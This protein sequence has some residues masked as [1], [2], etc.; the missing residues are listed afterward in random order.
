MRPVLIFR[1]LVY[2]LRNPVSRLI[3]FA[4]CTYIIFALCTY[5]GFDIA[6]TSAQDADT[7]ASG[8]ESYYV[9]DVVGGAPEY[10]YVTLNGLMDS[11]YSFVEVTKERYGVETSKNPK[12]TI[13]HAL[14]TEE[15]AMNQG[16]GEKLHADVLVKT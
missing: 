16:T 5:A 11:S 2:L 12:N 3:I 4:L 9:E 8:P 1:L 14:F 6:R 10:D 15:E 7:Y 13:Y